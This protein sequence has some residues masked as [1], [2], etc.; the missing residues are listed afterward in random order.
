MSRVVT[1]YNVSTPKANAT[2]GGGHV[3]LVQKAMK[4]LKFRSM[5][6]P[7]SVEARGVHRKQEL[8]TYFYRDDGYRV[9]E[10]TRRSARFYGDECF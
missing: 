1:C 3:Q 5:C 10:A 4:S 8:P 2:G 7:D 6:F 9:W